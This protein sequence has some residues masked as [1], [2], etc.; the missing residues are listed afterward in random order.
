MLGLA[1]PTDDAWVAAALADVPRLLVDHAHCEMKA[2]SNAMSLAVQNG[3]RP[4]LVDA[5]TALAMEEL[6]HFRRVH[7][8][9]VARGIVF[10]P[11]E[12]DPYAA[13]LRTACNALGP[14]PSKLVDR[15]LV[16]CLIEARSCERFRILGERAED[17]ELRAMW[18]ELLASEAGHYR[19]FLDLAI[20]VG[21]EEG[22][23]ADRIRGRLRDLAAA[24]GTIVRELSREPERATVHG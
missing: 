18:Q 7:A 10:T 14:S 8:I 1:S 2:A 22:I 4:A 9:I 23:G 15:L 24:E 16:G 3:H 12:V 5:L 13:S 20:V 6:E 11:P 19:T 21:A 17:P